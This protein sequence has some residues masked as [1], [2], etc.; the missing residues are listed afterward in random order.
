MIDSELY[1]VGKEQATL[2]YVESAAP[3]II[4]KKLIINASIKTVYV[5]NTK[6]KYTV[7][8]VEDWLQDQ[9]T[10]DYMSY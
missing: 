2:N 5:R 10:N 8:N 9:N 6:D 7:F 1:L 3:C 4:C